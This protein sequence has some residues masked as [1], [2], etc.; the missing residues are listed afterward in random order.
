MEDPNQKQK[1]ELIYL[2]TNTERKLSGSRLKSKN[3]EIR[4]YKNVN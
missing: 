3:A 2:I 4:R 1:Y